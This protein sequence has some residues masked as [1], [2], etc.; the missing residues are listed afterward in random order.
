MKSLP[1]YLII[2]MIIGCSPHEE[3]QK[4]AQKFID[5]YTTI[6]QKLS[7][8]SA[9]AQWK[10]NTM[11]IEGDTVIA[12]ATRNAE[13]A[14]AEFTGSQM[15]IENARMLLKDKDKLYTIQVKQ[16]ER[17]LYEAGNN[18]QTVKEIVEERIKA[19][20]EQTNKLFGFNFKID[21][22]SVSTN[23]IDNILSDKKSRLNKRLKVWN[24]SKEVGK[25]LKN[26]IVKLRR[27][28]NETVQALG[29]ND[30][31][32]YQ[33]SDYGM[34]TDEMMELMLKINREIRPLYRELHTY[35]RY[36]L[37]KKYGV[38]KVPDQLP[39]HWLPNRWGQDWSGMLTVKGFDLDE[40]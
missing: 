7:Y 5:E 30:Y 16:L 23:K 36:E 22:K 6:Y 17:V 40:V 26:G 32:T 14:L 8:M 4:K 15:N 2:L 34:T 13:K 27:L 11:I 35:A 1:V 3:I 29:Y 38:K 9:E 19:E 21:G 12:T 37:A 10:S 18:P 25:S 20:T 31:F 33:V 39:A 24:A 28:R